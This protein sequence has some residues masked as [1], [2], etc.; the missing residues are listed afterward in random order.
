[1][2]FLKAILRFFLL[3]LTVEIFYENMKTADKSLPPNCFESYKK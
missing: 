2:F 1:M 3:K